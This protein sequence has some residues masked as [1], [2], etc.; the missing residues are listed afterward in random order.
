MGVFLLAGNSEAAPSPPR[1]RGFRGGGWIFINPSQSQVQELLRMELIFLVL[2]AFFRQPRPGGLRGGHPEMWQPGLGQICPLKP[3]PAPVAPKASRG[4]G[5]KTLQIPLG[6]SSTSVSTSRPGCGCARAAQGWFFPGS[7]ECRA[8]KTPHPCT[9]CL[10]SWE[11]QQNRES[12]LTLPSV[13]NRLFQPSKS[14]SI[15]PQW[16]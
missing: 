15:H 16:M 12:H 8:T 14:L 5:F 13:G 10:K 2:C 9:S 3:P 11:I 1:L 4:G 6:V 7:P